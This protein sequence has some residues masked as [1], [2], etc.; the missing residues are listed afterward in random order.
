[1]LKTRK[2][3]GLKMYPTYFSFP[4]QKICEYYPDQS[5]RYCEVTEIPIILHLPHNIVKCQDDLIK[6]ARKFPALK[7][8]VAHMGLIYLPID[9]F[10]EAFSLCKQI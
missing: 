9:G 2:F 10:E 3:Y 7:I 6:T 5:L 8:I 4:A 1:M